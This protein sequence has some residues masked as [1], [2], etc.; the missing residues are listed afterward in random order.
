MESEN[1][2]Y[3]SEDSFPASV[4]QPAVEKIPASQAPDSSGDEC[5]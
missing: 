5:K 4:L 3:E 1:D 2:M